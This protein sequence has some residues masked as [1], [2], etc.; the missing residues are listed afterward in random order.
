MERTEGM[1]EPFGLDVNMLVRV[2][3]Y[4]N[5]GVYVTDK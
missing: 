1:S 2:L 3:N 5:A 4:L